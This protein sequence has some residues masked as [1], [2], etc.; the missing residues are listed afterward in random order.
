MPKRRTVIVGGLAL[1]VTGCASN[2]GTYSGPEVTRVV[3]Q[4]GARR[5]FLL[6]G[7]AVLQ[8]YN[9][10]LGFEPRGDKQIEGDGKTPE[11]TYFIDRKNPQSAFYLSLGISYPNEQDVAQAKAL[12]EEPGG[13]IFIHGASGTLG[14]RG[15][16]WTY[17]C[18]AV[19]NREIE[20]VYAMVNEG[21]QV[22]L[23]P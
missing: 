2:I 20:D 5:M 14:Q 6:N 12:G 19:S 9:I 3:I 1:A 23:F 10:D 17:G 22:D 21:T 8:A 4:K 13:D 7:Q 18:I 16:D 15:T 11:G